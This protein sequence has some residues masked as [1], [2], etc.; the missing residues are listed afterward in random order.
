MAAREKSERTVQA[1]RH[2]ER[3]RERE[4]MR[5]TAKQVDEDRRVSN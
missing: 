3:E 2:R 1:V 4:R 5:V